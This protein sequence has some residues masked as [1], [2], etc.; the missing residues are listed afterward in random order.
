MLYITDKPSIE[1]KPS[2][3]IENDT[4][5]FRCEGKYGGPCKEQISMGYC[6]YLKLFY[7]Q[8]PDS[9]L[10]AVDMTEWENN[11]LIKVNYHVSRIGFENRVWH[12]LDLNPG[13]HTYDTQTPSSK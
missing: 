3:L 4:A 2:I 1:L 12:E 7:S 8:D 10:L 13:T 9:E 11:T 6:P 5:V